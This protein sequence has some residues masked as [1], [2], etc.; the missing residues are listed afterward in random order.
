MEEGCKIGK[1]TTAHAITL[2]SDPAMSSGVGSRIRLS[3][4][5]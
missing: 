5:P 1:I 3:G 2:R 4:N